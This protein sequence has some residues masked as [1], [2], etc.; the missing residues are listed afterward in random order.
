[1]ALEWLPNVEGVDPDQ[2]GLALVVA[3]RTGAASIRLG[4]L[5]VS[6]DVATVLRN[7]CRRFLAELEEREAR[8]YAP[9][10]QLEPEEF[11]A[12]AAD[13]VTDHLGIVHGARAVAE[14]DL[15]TANDLRRRNL[16]FYAV[17]IGESPNESLFISKSNPSRIA[18][19]G[20]LVTTLRDGL[21][22]IDDP[23]FLF[24]PNFDLAA[25]PGGF[26]VLEQAVFELLFRQT[27]LLRTVVG[28]WVAEVA[29][30]LPMD[31]EDQAGLMARVQRD[32]RL[33]RRLRA[34]HERGHLRDVSIEMIRDEVVRNGLDP[35]RFIEGDRLVWEETDTHTLLRILNEDLF[36]GGLTGVPFMADRKT[37]RR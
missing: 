13:L 2:G 4:Q 21:A 36:T 34:I 20:F 22:R 37:S 18:H 25:L 28:S 33:A 7:N 27:E 16:L 30:H 12:I 17:V 24:D 15:M 3:W 35:S 23:I 9:E 14:L 26:A 31:P 1:V 5:N 19:R 32:S 10:G 11:F 29:D 6:T 8:Q